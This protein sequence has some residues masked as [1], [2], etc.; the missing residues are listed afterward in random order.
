MTVRLIVHTKIVAAVWKE[1]RPRGIG[2]LD[3]FEGER[4]GTTYDFSSH[5]FVGVEIKGY[6]GIAEHQCVS[7][8]A[9]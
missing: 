6:V 5:S 1:Q 9:K 3:K 4:S 2:G 7:R 8:K